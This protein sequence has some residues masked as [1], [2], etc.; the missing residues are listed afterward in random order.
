MR[1]TM[2]DN[3]SQV[4]EMSNAVAPMTML[5][6]GDPF[7][8]GCT[9]NIGGQRYHTVMLDDGRR[10]FIHAATAYRECVR[11]VANQE[12]IVTAEPCEDAIEVW[13]IH[14]GQPLYINGGPDEPREGWVPISTAT[15][16]HG[17]IMGEAEV[18]L[19]DKLPAQA[20]AKYVPLFAHEPKLVQGIGE[21]LLAGSV[22]VVL[23]L[24]VLT[25]SAVITAAIFGQVPP[26]GGLLV[27]FTLGLVG[28][29]TNAGAAAL[30][31]TR[32][33]TPGVRLRAMFGQ[34]FQ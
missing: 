34:M 5:R 4:F 30:T 7:V 31:W 16:T 21:F 9:T 1:A 22:S 26:A 3:Q 18:L 15:G 8:L 12:L 17:Y 13:R 23:W 10:G 29:L 11:A 2:M 25:L 19:L 27:L 24:A 28:S 20:A 32:G 6:R 33:L 14:N